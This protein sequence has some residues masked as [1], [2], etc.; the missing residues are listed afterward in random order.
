MG[1]TGLALRFGTS[2]PPEVVPPH[3]VI[4]TIAGVVVV[5]VVVVATVVHFRRRPAV[6]LVAI[7]ATLGMTVGAVSYTW[8]QYDLN[9]FPSPR[10]SHLLSVPGWFLTLVLLTYDRRRQRARSDV[11]TGRQ[12]WH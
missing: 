11:S 7:T 3:S 5:A 12:P 6:F 9:T 8:V 1:S 4:K 2:V 10:P